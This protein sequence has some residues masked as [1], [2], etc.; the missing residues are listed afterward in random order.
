MA[1]RTTDY[2]TTKAIAVNTKYDCTVK[3]ALSTA[4]KVNAVLT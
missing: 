3:C 1:T 2:D 4:N